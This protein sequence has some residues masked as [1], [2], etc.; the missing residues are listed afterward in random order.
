[1]FY[2][3]GAFVHPSLCVSAR[4]K[5]EYANNK[6]GIQTHLGATPFPTLSLIASVSLS[7]L[8]LPRITHNTCST[9]SE[10]S[11][12]PLRKIFRTQQE[13]TLWE[14]GWTGSL[15]DPGS[16]ALVSLVAAEVVRVAR[17]P[18][19][20]AGASRRDAPVLEP[21]EKVIPR[22]HSSTTGPIVTVL[23]GAAQR[24]RWPPRDMTSSS[25]PSRGA[26]I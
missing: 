16:S 2:V 10:A 4:G 14:G 24:E 23:H 26:S 6:E 3:H 21:M 7:T 22:K 13:G 8:L 18:L 11:P 17:L 12:A 15:V 20:L 9:S 19:F 5:K 1:M 25:S